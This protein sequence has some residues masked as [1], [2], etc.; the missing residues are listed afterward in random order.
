VLLDRLLVDDDRDL[1]VWLLLFTG[2]KIIELR[3]M[4]NRQNLGMPHGVV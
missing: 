2:E 1:L 3:H 4:H